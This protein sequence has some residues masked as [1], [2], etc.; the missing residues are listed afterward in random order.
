MLCLVA[1]LDAYLARK[2]D[3]ESG[4]KTIWLGIQHITDFANA[5]SWARQRQA[6]EDVCNGMCH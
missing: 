4:A 3:S 5:P 1:Q 6:G 2:A